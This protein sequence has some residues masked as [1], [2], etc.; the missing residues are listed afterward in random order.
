[1]ANEHVGWLYTIT[2]AA[3]A[4]GRDASQVRRW[5]AK[6][7]IP[8]VRREGDIRKRRYVGIAGIEKIMEMPR[9]GYRKVRTTRALRMSDGSVH[10]VAVIEDVRD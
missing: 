8:S 4:T 1:M 9:A 3:A 10:I 2:E 6:G 5:I 7:M